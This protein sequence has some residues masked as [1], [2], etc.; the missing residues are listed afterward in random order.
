MKLD[1]AAPRPADG[2]SASQ[3]P[4]PTHA[5]AT[6]DQP[7]LPELHLELAY[8]ARAAYGRQPPKGWQIVS[9]HE[10]TALG[11]ANTAKHWTDPITSFSAT[12]YHSDEHGYALAYAGTTASDPRDWMANMRQARGL[13]SV[14]YLRAIQLA[15]SAA[16]ALRK[17]HPDAKITLTGHS[18]GGG[19]A[20]AGALAAR[21]PAVTFNA[22]GLHVH[23][24]TLALLMRDGRSASHPNNVQAY[25]LRGE[26][27]THAQQTGV[28]PRAHGASR[29]LHPEAPMR[30]LK[31]RVQA[32]SMQAVID[33]L[34]KR[35][36][37]VPSLPSPGARQRRVKK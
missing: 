14:Q 20:S 36:I 24:K 3:A 13:A 15:V 27:L 32:H 9:H 28:L 16:K 7:C 1:R 6:D 29:S 34:K 21:I 30:S 33:G 31:S 19:L 25:A 12:L 11:L 4:E 5:T 26:V 35:D 22:A 10:L 8:L 37:C 17:G 23:T 2:P 18:L